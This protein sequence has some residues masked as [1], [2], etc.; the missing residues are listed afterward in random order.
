VY[1]TGGDVTGNERTQVY[2]Q[3]KN[4]FS[5]QASDT[6]FTAIAISVM[7]KD[8]IRRVVTLIYQD[9]PDML[10]MSGDGKTTEALNQKC[11]QTI[12]VLMSL[13]DDGRNWPS[14][15]FMNV[16][17]R[18]PFKIMTN[19]VA[20]NPQ[21]DR[22]KD[23]YLT[24]RQMLDAHQGEFIQFA[25]VVP[26]V[27]KEVIFM[28]INSREDYEKAKVKQRAQLSAGGAISPLLDPAPAVAFL[29]AP[30]PAPLPPIIIQIQHP[31]APAPAPAPASDT[32]FGPGGIAGALFTMWLI[33]NMS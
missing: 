14:N 22:V 6:F 12:K 16:P 26:E 1:V 24:V 9:M 2:L 27:D 31:P 17:N 33:Y 32:G 10:W 4:A 15:G 3:L 18:I 29:D 11:E 7:F 19:I 30:A 23:K 8:I 5:H 25:E 21:L 28:G 13:T 20:L